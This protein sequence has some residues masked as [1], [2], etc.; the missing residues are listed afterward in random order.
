MVV[1]YNK[2]DEVQWI[3]K[4]CI[5]L[6]KGKISSQASSFVDRRIRSYY[7]NDEIEFEEV[8]PLEISLNGCSD[9]IE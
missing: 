9:D 1:I 5:Q 6:C 2:V 8:M 7:S 4:I 3:R